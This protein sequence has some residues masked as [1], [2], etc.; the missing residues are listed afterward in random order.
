MPFHTL[1]HMKFKIQMFNTKVMEE[2][3]EEAEA[4]VK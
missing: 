3:E 1:I 4:V 2:E